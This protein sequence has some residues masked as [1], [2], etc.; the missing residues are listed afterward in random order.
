MLI[1]QATGIYTYNADDHKV[2]L[3]AADDFEDVREYLRLKGRLRDVGV[4]EGVWRKLEAAC[5]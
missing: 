1:S 3:V 5:H 2:A 4:P